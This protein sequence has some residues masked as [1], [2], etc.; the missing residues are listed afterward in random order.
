MTVIANLGSLINISTGGGST[1]PVQ[2]PFHKCGLVSGVAPVTVAA[3]GRVMSLWGFDGQPSGSGSGTTAPSTAVVTNNAT[4]GSLR[5]ATPGAGVDL[6]LNSVAVTSLVAGT[7]IVYDRLVQHGGLSGTVI[8]AQTTNL[9]TPSLTRY[10]SGAGVELWLESYTAVGTTATTVA[11]SY[12][13][14]TPTSGQT[15]PLATFG[16]AGYDASQ[17]VVPLALQVGDIGVTAVAS[18][19]VTASTLTAGNF[20]V[21]LAYPLAVIPIPVAGAGAI[22]S[23]L[24]LTGGPLDLGTATDSCI[25]FAWVGLAATAPYIR[26]SAYFIYN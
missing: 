22:W 9:P 18:V 8:T 23:G 10:T 25:A 7:F 15:T 17:Q 14:T 24:T 16:G 26:G 4:S 3:A 21:T 2:V 19:T 1:A 5:Q 12:T 20:G 6:F 13:N 11:A